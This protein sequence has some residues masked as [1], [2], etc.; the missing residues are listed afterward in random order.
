MRKVGNWSPPFEFLT[1][2][3][4]KCSLNIFSS[5]HIY[6][7]FSYLT[8]AGCVWNKH[9]KDSSVQL[10]LV[11]FCRPLAL[12]SVSIVWLHIELNRDAEA[13]ILAFNLPLI[14]YQACT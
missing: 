14:N 4:A 1:L 9:L 12:F 5:G 2:L 8:D 3:S 7:I 6:C 13:E 11:S 10:L